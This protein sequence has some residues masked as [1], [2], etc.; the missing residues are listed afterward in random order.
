MAPFRL[1]VRLKVIQSALTHA[2]TGGAGRKEKV[3][4]GVRRLY[5][6]LIWFIRVRWSSGSST[7]AFS[8]AK[9]RRRS[10]NI[11]QQG[12]FFAEG[13]VVSTGNRSTAS[14]AVFSLKNVLLC[15]FNIVI[16][17]IFRGKAILF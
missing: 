11:K 7:K 15:L 16:N 17:R 2:M 10:F 6:P 13:H 5:S 8:R 9:E 12:S 4:T 1:N 3:A 14:I